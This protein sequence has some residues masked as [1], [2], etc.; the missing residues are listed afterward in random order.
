LIRRL[1]ERQMKGFRALC[2]VVWVGVI[3]TGSY[4]MGVRFIDRNEQRSGALDKLVTEY[5]WQERFMSSIENQR[6][7]LISGGNVWDE[8]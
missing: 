1:V 7:R 4:H 5:L 2:Q 3:S 6:N 8:S